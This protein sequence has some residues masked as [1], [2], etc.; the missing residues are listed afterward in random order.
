MVKDLP[1]DLLRVDVERAS[2]ESVSW[3]E[4]PHVLA[5]RE[6]LGLDGSWEVGPDVD[7]HPQ[8]GRREKDPRSD[9]G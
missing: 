8:Q 3:A 6:Q 1:S 7:D 4:E 2:G 5:V 9:G